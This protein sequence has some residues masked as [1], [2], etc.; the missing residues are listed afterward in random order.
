MLSRALVDDI[1]RPVQVTICHFFFKDNELQSSL[2]TALCAILHQLFSHEP[3]LI[4]FAFP[5]WERNGGKLAQESSALWSVFLKAAG[6]AKRPVVCVLD[7][8]DECVQA[9]RSRLIRML[10][11]FHKEAS[12]GNHRAG[13]KFLA[14]SRPYDDVRRWFTD[15]I[16]SCPTIWLR[17]DEENDKINEEINIVIDGQVRKLAAEFRLEDELRERLQSSL[18]NIG[19]RTYLWLHLTLDSIRDQIQASIDPNRIRI[20]DISLPETVEQAYEALLSRVKNH[21]RECVR[22]VFL[23]IIG[24]RRPFTSEEMF[25]ALAVS[26]PE[27]GRGPNTRGFVKARFEGQI[28]EWCGLFV[29][30]KDSKLFLIHQTAKEFLLAR[31]A[32]VVWTLNGE[33]EVG[34]R[35][36]RSCLPA[37]QVEYEMACICVDYLCLEID[38]GFLDVDYGGDEATTIYA[39]FMEVWPE[40]GAIQSLYFYCADNWNLHLLDN[41][42]SAER[43]IFSKVLRI[44]QHQDAKNLLPNWA[45]ASERLIETFF[46]SLTNGNSSL[47]SQWWSSLASG[48]PPILAQHLMAYSGHTTTLKYLSEVSEVDWEAEDVGGRTALVYAAAMGHIGTIGFLVEQNANV[49]CEPRHGVGYSWRDWKPPLVYAV[50]KRHIYMV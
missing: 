6:S 33:L 50:Q 36:W 49:Y 24:A 42:I 48:R 23:I 19:H 25:L 21:L 9:D 47:S 18:K 5:E 11:D 15:T 2:A 3:H 22:K 46:R 32:S 34:T 27:A 16:V 13:L 26:F 28:R 20:E 40:G 45:S 39:R 29:F 35:A 37:A 8:L 14:T 41:E 31:E 1:P 12:S 30:I 10:C 17:G 44:Y 7:A 43:P 4:Q 38:E